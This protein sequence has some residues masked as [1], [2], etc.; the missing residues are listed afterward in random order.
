MTADEFN[1]LGKEQQKFL[2]CD[3]DK[4]GENTNETRF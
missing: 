2:L 4:I 1:G 3:A